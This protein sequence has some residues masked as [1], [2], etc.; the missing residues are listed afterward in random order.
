MRRS[1]KRRRAG[2]KPAP[3]SAAKSAPVSGDRMQQGDASMA[4]VI[5]VTSGKGGV[6]KT[7]TS[8]AFATGLALRGQEDRGDR[9][10]RGPAQPRPHH[11]LRAPRGVRL[12]QR[13][14]G[15][16]AA[17]PGADQGQAG[18]E[19]VHPAGLAD[20]GQGR[21]DQGR[22]RRDH[23]GAEPGFR[24]HPLRQ[25]GRHREGRADG[26]VLRRPGD[27]RDQPGSLLGARQRP[28]PRRAGSRSRS[29]RRRSGSR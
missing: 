26:A 27:R 25:P 5:V 3:G 12:R 21:A 15:R 16:G 20:P 18:R 4:Q 8:A 29:G 10:R 24:L 17:E 28:H 13:H 23:R 1:G 2:G 19:P 22:R 14:P 6:G 9:L 11:G 7:T